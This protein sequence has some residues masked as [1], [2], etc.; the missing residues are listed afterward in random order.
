VETKQV[1]SFSFVVITQWNVVLQSSEIGLTFEQ[2]IF[3]IEHCFAR[4]LCVL[5]QEGFQEVFPIKMMLK[6]ITVH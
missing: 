5:Y 1:D 3:I 4:N 2:R 6:K